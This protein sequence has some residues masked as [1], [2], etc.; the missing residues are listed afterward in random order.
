MIYRLN[1]VK[2]FIGARR[3]LMRLNIFEFK[4]KKYLDYS[5]FLLSYH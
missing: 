3:E 4:K 1:A 5:Y 2:N